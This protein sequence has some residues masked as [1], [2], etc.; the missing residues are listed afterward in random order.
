MDI[1]ELKKEHEELGIYYDQLKSL[2][3]E[4][5]EVIFKDSKTKAKQKKL[6]QEMYKINLKQITLLQKIS[7]INI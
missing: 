5:D 2:Y 7:G 6:G 1:A 4:I 3:K